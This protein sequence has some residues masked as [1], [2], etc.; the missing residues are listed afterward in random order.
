MRFSWSWLKGNAWLLP[1]A[2]YTAAAIAR[3]VY[4]PCF[5]VDRTGINWKPADTPV[6][7][8]P[9]W[10]VGAEAWSWGDGMSL[11]HVRYDLVLYEEIV[12]L[13]CVAAW[14]GTAYALSPQMRARISG[15]RAG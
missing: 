9:V 13:A 15:L 2:I 3:M 10:R 11:L 5:W 8:I 12:L 6:E 7:T 4:V 1:L 14:Y